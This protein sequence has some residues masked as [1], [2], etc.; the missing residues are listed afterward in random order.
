MNKLVVGLALLISSSCLA[1]NVSDLE[2]SIARDHSEKTSCELRVKELHKQIADLN[3]RIART[4]SA[5]AVKKSE[6]QRMAAQAAAPV[7]A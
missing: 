1:M 4:E 6:A 5:L 2:T 3:E 7:A